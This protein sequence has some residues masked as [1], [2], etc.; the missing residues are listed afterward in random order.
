M[1]AIAPGA[2]ALQYLYVR[3]FALLLLLH[4]ENTSVNGRIP[5][6]NSEAGLIIQNTQLAG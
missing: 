5:R 1:A 4:T 2:M 3:V 6:L